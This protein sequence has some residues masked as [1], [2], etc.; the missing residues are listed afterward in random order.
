MPAVD[1]DGNLLPPCPKK[2]DPC[3]ALFDPKNKTKPNNTQPND[4]PKKPTPSDDDDDKT[5]PKKN[6]TNTVTVIDVKHPRL[7]RIIDRNRGTIHTQLSM[8]NVTK[9]TFA[10]TQPPLANP[11]YFLTSDKF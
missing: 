4:T 2:E 7:T 3:D 6:G 9:H 5:K 1:I 10:V 8:G 11:I